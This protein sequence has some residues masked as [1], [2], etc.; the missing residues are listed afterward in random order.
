MNNEEIKAEL[1]KLIEKRKTIDENTSEA[2]ICANFVDQLLLLFGWDI[3][4]V[5][6]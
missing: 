6:Q 1:K 5:K 3:G 4:D 2:N